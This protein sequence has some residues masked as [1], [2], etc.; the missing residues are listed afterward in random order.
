MRNDCKDGGKLRLRLWAG[1]A[2]CAL[3]AAM[4]AA[5]FPM[6]PARAQLGAS[7]ALLSD[8]SVRGMSLSRGRP[9][10][11]LRLDY[12]ARGG[13]YAGALGSRVALADSDARLQLL[14]YG[15]YAHQLPGGSSWE[16]GALAST[17]AGDM[18]YRYHE[19]YAGLTRDGLGG[20]LYYS[21]AY[22]G[23]GKT[24][25][26]ELNGA[27]P[28]PGRLTLSGHVGL[29]HPLG[30]GGDEARQ[31]V[32][33]RVALGMD[34]GDFNFQVAVVAAS[35]GGREAARKLAVGLTRDF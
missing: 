10:P 12:D 21:P 22:Y 1:R 13:W 27:W 15:G 30:D 16:A 9:A 2:G 20:R 3:I 23:E 7:A 17:F 4:F 5:A 24:L 28:L 32:D 25:Y 29:L 18:H 14:A 35:P 33:L 26:F 31:R 19:F 6:R 11:Q 34:V 8:Y